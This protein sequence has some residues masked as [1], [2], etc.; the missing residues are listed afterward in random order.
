[1]KSDGLCLTSVINCKTNKNQHSVMVSDIQSRQYV[2][3]RN[4]GESMKRSRKCDCVVSVR[5]KSYEA[6]TFYDIYTITHKT[7]LQS[8]GT[9]PLGKQSA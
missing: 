7:T 2:C 6:S 3:S 4:D 9:I 8:Q 1:M 5:K